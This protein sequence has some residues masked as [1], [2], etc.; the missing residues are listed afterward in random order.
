MIDVQSF[1]LHVGTRG[2]EIKSNGVVNRRWKRA[3]RFERRQIEKIPR[4]STTLRVHT[5]NRGKRRRF[6]FCIIHRAGRERAPFVRQSPVPFRH[7]S[8]GGRAAERR[9]PPTLTCTIISA[10]IKR[11]GRRDVSLIDF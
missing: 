6:S 7:F 9:R 2:S 5:G 11:R 4:C 10:G 1:V 8:F 3:I